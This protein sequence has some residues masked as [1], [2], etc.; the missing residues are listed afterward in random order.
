MD[1]VLVFYNPAFSETRQRQIALGHAS[2]MSSQPSRGRWLRIPLGYL[3]M[4]LPRDIF[5]HCPR[6]GTG[7]AL[8]RHV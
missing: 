2:E 6:A 5:I 3:L 1:V 4:L 7:R 8:I